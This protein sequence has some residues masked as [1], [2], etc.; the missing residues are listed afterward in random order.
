[1]KCF[2]TTANIAH[3]LPLYN[4]NNN[5]FSAFDD[6]SYHSFYKSSLYKFKP[7]VDDLNPFI[8]SEI[9]KINSEVPNTITFKNPEIV[10]SEAKNY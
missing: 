2:A 4:L 7:C 3:Q 8:F 1:M 9:E 10:Q 6:P 5:T